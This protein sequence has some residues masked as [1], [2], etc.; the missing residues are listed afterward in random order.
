MYRSFQPS[1]ADL[2]NYEGNATVALLLFHANSGSSPDEGIEK[3]PTASEVEASMEDGV[4]NESH[5]IHNCGSTDN[6]VILE[7]CESLAEELRE[8]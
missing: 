8:S 4:D 7:G 5:P 6:F 2:A 1:S 3:I